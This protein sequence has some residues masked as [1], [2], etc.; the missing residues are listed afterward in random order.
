[1]GKAMLAASQDFE[2]VGLMGVE[3]ERLV[4]LTFGVSGMLGG[5]AG[6]LVG[7]LYA[8]DPMMGSMAGLKGWAVAVLG[9]VGSISGAMVAGLLL[10][11]A[12]NVS[13]AYISSGYR[14]A[15]AF[16][17]MILTLIV[18]PTGLMG[19]KFEEKV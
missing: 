17:A 5:A 3:V 13:S 16:I 18:K 14:D 2:M 15:I 1:M 4:M 6:V 7:V 8:I 12:E 9:G 11:I 19:Y 10:G